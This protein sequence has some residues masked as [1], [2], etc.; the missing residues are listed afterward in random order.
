MIPLRLPTGATIG[1]ACRWDF[2]LLARE[3]LLNST[4]DA[5]SRKPVLNDVLVMLNHLRRISEETSGRMINSAQ[6]ALEGT[7]P[8]IHQQARWQNTNDWFRFHRIHR[9]FNRDDV[10]PP[11]E[12]VVHKRLSTIY[13]LTM[14]IVG[15][16][17]NRLPITNATIDYTVFGI[18]NDERGAFTWNPLEEN[19]L[20]QLHECRTAKSSNTVKQRAILSISAVILRHLWQPLFLQKNRVISPPPILLKDIKDEC[21]SL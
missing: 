11:L 5:S 8:L 20:I 13:L 17:R 19:Q 10:R 6:F 12:G 15:A 7:H 1:E 4:S 21:H 18:L 16:A 14:A 3:A 9:V 2:H